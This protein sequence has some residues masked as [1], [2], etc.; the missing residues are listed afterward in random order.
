M[1]LRNEAA[2][3]L[4][5]PLRNCVEAALNA[6]VSPGCTSPC[7]PS[8]V[9]CCGSNFFSARIEVGVVVLLLLLQRGKLVRHVLVLSAQR[10]DLLVQLVETVGLIEDGALCGRQLARQAI[11]LGT[12]IEN[13][14]D[15]PGRRRTC[16]RARAR[17]SRPSLPRRRLRRS[18]ARRND[19]SYGSSLYVTVGTRGRRGGFVPTTL[20]HDRRQRLFL[21]QAHGFHLRIR[22]AQQRQRATH[23]FSTL[24]AECQVVLA[25][26]AFVGVALDQDVTF[27]MAFRYAR[28]VASS[29]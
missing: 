8:T 14:P 4:K 25:R 9:C 29:D 26:A 24:L 13:R 16:P 1:K 22:H 11:G 28:V 7:T 15:G 10:R 12:Q 2:A 27:R 19:A 20:R 18:A 6:S 5:S 23:S 3:F 21:A 17:P